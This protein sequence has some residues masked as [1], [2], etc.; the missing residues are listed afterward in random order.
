VTTNEAAVPG[1]DAIDGDRSGT[2]VG[3]I[4][5][6]TMRTPTITV[7]VIVIDD[8]VLFK[9]SPPTPTS[10]GDAVQAAACG[11]DVEDIHSQVIAAVHAC[12]SGRTQREYG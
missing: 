11:E 2:V 9:V 5:V 7:K 6:G 10:G 4:G 3:G 8:Q 1:P 12:R